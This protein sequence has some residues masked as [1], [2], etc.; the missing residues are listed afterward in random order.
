MMRNAVKAANISSMTMRMMT[1]RA[2]LS[3]T[4]ESGTGSR[5]VRLAGAA[6]PF[7]SLP[8]D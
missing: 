4:R 1:D 6:F 5:P 3:E 8:E 2:L 7:S